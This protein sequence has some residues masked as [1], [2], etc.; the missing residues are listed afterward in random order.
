MYSRIS[1]CV[2]SKHLEIEDWE[3]VAPA[4]VA[5]LPLRV[6][7][8]GTGLLLVAVTAWLFRKPGR[9]APTVPA[10]NDGPVPFDK[11]Q[12][13]VEA[14]AV[15]CLM[16]LLSPMSSKSHYV[17]TLLPSLLIARAIVER[18]SRWL[19]WLLVPLIACGPLSTKG[20]IGRSLGDLTLVW[21]LPVWFALT[22]L[23]GIWMVLRAMPNR[24]E[25]EA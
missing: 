12:T 3:N 9:P 14:A 18:R 1:S 8:Y 22:S 25:A 24:T 6:A 20:L 4:P 23:V 11:L 16:L 21:G 2:L 13:G 17:V 10:P 7:V 5:T 15:V 19:P